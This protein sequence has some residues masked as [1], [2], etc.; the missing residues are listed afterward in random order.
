[1]LVYLPCAASVRRLKEPRRTTNVSTRSAASPAARC[2]GRRC[3]R[4]GWRAPSASG[5]ATIWATAGRISCFVDAAVGKRKAAF[6]H[7][8]LAKD[9]A[10]A[11]GKA[12]E[13]HKLPFDAIEYKKADGDEKGLPGEAVY[14]KAVGKSWKINLKDQSL[15]EDTPGA[16]KVSVIR[17]IP[18]PRQEASKLLFSQSPQPGPKRLC[19]T[20]NRPNPNCSSLNRPRK[21]RTPQH[22]RKKR[23]RS[24]PSSRTTMSG[25]VSARTARK[26][27]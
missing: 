6:D 20:R 11:T 10:K 8:R 9:L 27:L 1:M 26:S 17:G 23:R 16:K 12:F 25:F 14:F 24:R 13:A 3:K 5:I 7:E 18:A 15:T 4:I 2:F 21:S 22:R 19:R